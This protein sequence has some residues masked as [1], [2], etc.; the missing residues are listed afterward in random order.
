MTDRTLSLENIRSG[1]FPSDA[2]AV[3]FLLT[4]IDRLQGTLGKIAG[5]RCHRLDAG[6]GACSRQPGWAPNAENVSQRWCDACLAHAALLPQEHVLV[7]ASTGSSPGRPT[8][9]LTGRKS[10]SPG[11]RLSAQATGPSEPVPNKPASDSDRQYYY[12]NVPG[13]GNVAVSRHAQE[14]MDEYHI[15]RAAFERS[16]L[17]PANEVEDGPE[18][19][20]RERDGIRVVILH[21]P[22]PF[23]GAKLVKTVMKVGAQAGARGG[24]RS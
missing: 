16:L 20:W 21:K 2:V 6:P 8:L 4:E 18:I 9:A 7:N 12:P 17:D 15:S 23:R 11:T 14:R 13:L 1:A 3:G 22:Q 24:R 5:D 10:P 19:V